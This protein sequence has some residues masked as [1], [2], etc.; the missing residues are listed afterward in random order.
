LYCLDVDLVIL[1]LRGSLPALIY[2]GGQGYM[3]PSMIL[4]WK[5]YSSTTRVVSFYI[6]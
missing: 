3:N 1:V 5:S 2:P 4:A 6:D